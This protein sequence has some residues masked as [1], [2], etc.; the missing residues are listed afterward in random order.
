VSDETL[1]VLRCLF[2]FTEQK[3]EK[4]DFE[5]DRIRCCKC[6]GELFVLA[7]PRDAAE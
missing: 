1:V 2:C 5:E 4:E 6:G 7:D 3:A